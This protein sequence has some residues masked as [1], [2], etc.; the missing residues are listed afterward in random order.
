M[1][2]VAKMLDDAICHN[3]ASADVTSI[4][5]GQATLGAI[6]FQQVVGYALIYFVMGGIFVAFALIPI[7]LAFLLTRRLRNPLAKILIR[8]AVMGVF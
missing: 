1:E 7:G 5:I 4:S 6:P 2:S 3:R 8:T